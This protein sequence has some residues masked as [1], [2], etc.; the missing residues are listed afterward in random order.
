MD[1]DKENADTAR[2]RGERLIPTAEF[3]ALLREQAQRLAGEFQK[4]R[5]KQFPPRLSL[6]LDRPPEA[7]IRKVA[8]LMLADLP[9][10]EEKRR[11][12][13]LVG[14]DA[15]LNGLF[16]VAAFLCT[17]SWI[18]NLSPAEGWRAKNK[19]LPVPSQCPDR[20]EGLVVS[21]STL[22]GRM[23]MAIAD[24]QRYGRGMT[25]G[26]WKFHD[27]A[28]AKTGVAVES[29]LLKYFFAGHYLG[30]MTRDEKKGEA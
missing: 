4:E 11:K 26:P 1:A 22:D 24:I 21:G 28:N 2:A 15:A 14:A 30:Q 8:V 5:Q 17:E 6:I 13:F 29:D 10:G 27:F 3:D 9:D 12:L 20:T 16:P 19:P 23:N 18:K 25:L 7:G